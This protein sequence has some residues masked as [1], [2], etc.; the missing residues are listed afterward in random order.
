[1]L[2]AYDRER[3][4]TIYRLLAD[5]LEH[6]SGDDREEERMSYLLG[7]LAG[8]LFMGTPYEPPDDVLAAA[9]DI[10]RT[11][12][13]GDRTKFAARLREIASLLEKAASPPPAP[14]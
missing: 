5:V 4:S 6:E 13:R 8:R 1:M 3:F 2:D 7:D 11:G 14:R 9:A 10:L 12:S